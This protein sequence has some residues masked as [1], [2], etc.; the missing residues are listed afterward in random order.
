MVGECGD[1]PLPKLPERNTPVQVLDRPNVAVREG[2]LSLEGH[3][4]DLIARGEM[5]EA[6]CPLKHHFAP[7]AYG[8]EIFIPADS[9]LV[10]KIHKHGHLNM[11]MKGKVSVMTEE[12]PRTYVGPLVMVSQPGTKRVVYAHEDTMWVTVH[13]TDSQDLDEIEEQIIAKTYEEFDAIQHD[14]RALLEYAA[15]QEEVSP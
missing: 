1:Y 5:P 3:L 12:G 9:L 10:G 14:C 4:K 2:I 8:R 6:D 7:G 11:I 13:L 15:N